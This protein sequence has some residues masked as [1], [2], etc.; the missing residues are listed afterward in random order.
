MKRLLKQKKPKE[1][2]EF[3][4][5]EIHPYME[6]DI[7]SVVQENIKIALVKNKIISNLSIVKIP[8]GAY[9]YYSADSDFWFEGSFEVFFYYHLNLKGYVFVEGYFTDPSNT[10]LYLRVMTIEIY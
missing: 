7:K 3:E 1:I 10:E 9:N 4:I 6:M 5:G 8:E 2:I